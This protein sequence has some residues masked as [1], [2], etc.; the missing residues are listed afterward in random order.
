MFTE[1]QTVVASLLLSLKFPVV[2]LLETLMFKTYNKTKKEKK[3]REKKKKKKRKKK[4]K[5]GKKTAH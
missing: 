3:K 2:D 4:E 5:K 1:T